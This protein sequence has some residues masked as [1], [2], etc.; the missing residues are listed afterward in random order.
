MNKLYL[1]FVL[2]KENNPI[3]HRSI[4]KIILNPLLSLFGIAIATLA[5]ENLNKSK[6]VIIQVKKVK[7]KNIIKRI[8]SSIFYEINDNKILSIRKLY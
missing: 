6:I 5:E 1:G 7:F 8:K 4:L 2:D 3:N